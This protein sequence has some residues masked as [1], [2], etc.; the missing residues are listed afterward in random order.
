MPKE[1]LEESQKENEQL[2]N[3]IK[4]RDTQLE[5]LKTNT[6][7]SKELKKQLEEAIAKNKADAE[8]AQA[9][10]A[11]YKKE[12]AL[13]MALLKSGAKNTKAVLALLDTDKI[14][15]DV[16][17]LLGF[18]DQVE[19]LK[20]SDAYLFETSPSMQGYETKGGSGDTD[21]NGA[22]DNPFDKKTKNLTKQAE[23]WAK[24]P[25]QAM[26]LAKQAG[27]IP[28]WMK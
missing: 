9:D 6:G 12:N 17:N 10:F 4:E 15:L 8:K 22:K 19:K 20:T 13:T 26:K 28:V 14:S 18:N 11:A 3:T 25:Q 1:K 21:P 7:D 27:N 23:L 2:Q 16:D 5:E 24:D